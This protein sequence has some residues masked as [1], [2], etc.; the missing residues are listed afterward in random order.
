M[1]TFVSWLIANFEIMTTVLLCIAFGILFAVGIDSSAF[2]VQEKWGLIGVAVFFM[3]LPAS[4]TV[5][6][7]EMSMIL[8]LLMLAG[9]I[10]VI[11]SPDVVSNATLP[12][13]PTALI[14][15]GVVSF[16]VA[17][18]IGIYTAINMDDVVSRRMLY[19][20]SDVDM[21]EMTLKYSLNRFMAAFVYISWAG[22]WVI[23]Y[24]TI[25]QVEAM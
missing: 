5:K 19:V 16:V 20:N 10:Y 24:N 9:Y 15:S 6:N 22:L 7:F 21:F 13:M 18:A 8:F 25:S 4:I 11:V 23:L 1:K 17:L 3:A 12:W 14:A 2:T